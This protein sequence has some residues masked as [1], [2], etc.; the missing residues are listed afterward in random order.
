K[1]KSYLL[2]SYR[3]EDKTTQGDAFTYAGH[4][5]TIAAKTSLPFWNRRGTFNVAYNFFHKDYKHITP[6]LGKERYDLQHSFQVNLAQPLYKSL[7]LNLNYEYIDSDSN[8]QESDFT[9]NIV[10]FAFS[11]AF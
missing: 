11:V 9:E 10:S 6:S 8:L 4:F 2:F 5:G 3:F 7:Q 1:G